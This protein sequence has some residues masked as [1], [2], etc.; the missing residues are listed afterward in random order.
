MSSPGG[1]EI[2]LPF[3]PDAWHRYKRRLHSDYRLP[4]VTLKQI[5]EAVPKDA[6]EKNTLKGLSY[7]ARDIFF[8][9]VFY[10]RE[11]TYAAS[12]R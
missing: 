1:D 6:Y 8:A 9:T 5:H 3:H 4:Q 12:L 11:N 10:V 7:V 2:S